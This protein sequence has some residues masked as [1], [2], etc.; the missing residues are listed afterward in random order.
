MSVDTIEH[1][2]A[3][4]VRVT[5]RTC[6]TFVELRTRDGLVGIGEAS[7]AGQEPALIAATERL[8]GRWVGAAVGPD[9]LARVPGPASLVEAAVISAVDQAVWDILARERGQSVAQA[10]GGVRRQRIPLYANINR[11]TLDRSPDGFASSARD[12]LASGYDAVKIAPFD[13]VV[14]G[15]GRGELARAIARGLARI[16]AVREAVGVGHDLLVDCHWRFDEAEAADVIRAAAAHDVHWIECPLRETPDNI[17]ALKRLRRRANRRG[18]RLAGCEEGV[19]VA[20]FEP[21]LTA[22]AYDVLMPDVKYVGGLPEMLRAADR[23][24]AHGV[25]FSPHNPTGPI[26][27]AA[28]LHVCAAAATVDRLEIQFDETPLFDAL[29]A[30]GL[31]SRTD[32]ASLLPASPRGLGVALDPTLLALHTADVTGKARV[33]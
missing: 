32:G 4:V 25:A 15:L 28:S 8:R 7:L 22:G 3:H 33:A 10:L 23:C 9:H 17:P 16:A 12:A 29:V 26:S 11:R 31:P 13:E 19:G 27:H 14:Q 18:I 5:A 30:N 20:A 24:A 1:V 2:D 6:W 21:F